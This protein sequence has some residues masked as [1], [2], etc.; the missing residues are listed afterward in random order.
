MKEKKVELNQNWDKSLSIA[1]EEVRR[2]IDPYHT[3]DIADYLKIAPVVGGVCYLGALV[4]QN[5]LPDLFIFA[6]P[7]AVGVFL[8]PILFKIFIS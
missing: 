1:T 6:Y 3:V 4:V 8:V 7:T 2:R 5:I